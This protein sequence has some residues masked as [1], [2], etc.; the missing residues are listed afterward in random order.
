MA[1]KFMERGHKITKVA[2]GAGFTCML[3][4][5]GVVSLTHSRQP[6][7]CCFS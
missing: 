4:L 1:I 7:S 2:G 6:T 5:T 3:L